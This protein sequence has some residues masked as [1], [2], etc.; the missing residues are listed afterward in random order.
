MSPQTFLVTGASG[1]IAKHIVH[2]LL[3]D[4]HAVRASVR[5]QAQA[6]AVAD[7]I[8][9][10]LSNPEALERLSF[11]VLN[12]EEDA[13]WEEAAFGVDALVHTASPFPARQPKDAQELVRPAVE[14]T[15]RALHAAAAANTSRVIMTSSIVAVTG[16]AL[17][18]GKVDY[19]ERDWTDPSSPL[20]SPYGRSKTLAEKAA[21]QIAEEQ[22]LDLTVINPG[23]VLGP[24]LD[25]RYGTSLSVVERMLKGRD[26]AVPR[27]GFPVVDVRDIAR[28]HVR[29][30]F[31]PQTI[32][33]RIIGAADFLWFEDMAK[34]LAKAFPDR[35]I[36]TRV[37]PDI[38]MRVISFF[39]GSVKTIL[40]ELGARRSTDNAKARALLDMEFIPA[41]EALLE[42]ARFLVS[43]KLA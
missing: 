30:L 37:A 3:V 11:V 33:H 7:T 16:S 25:G 40:P 42:A 15:R 43:R 35:R 13:G 1:F 17:A 27:V 21:W 29:A 34:T 14:G 18:A 19:D 20:A 2:Q 23:F 22:G 10:H 8:G 6:D 39:D 9:N 31:R 12:L 32:G 26:P 5:S 24:P 41:R 4:G 38:L 36:A 28:M